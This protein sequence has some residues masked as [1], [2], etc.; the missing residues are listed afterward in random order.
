MS[1]IG[2][3]A[4]PK[5]YGPYEFRLGDELRGER[6]TLGRSLLD[7]QR[8]LRIKAAYVAAIENCDPSVFPNPSF[9]A[10]YVRSY[11][12]YLGLDPD[13]IYWR[14][15]QESSFSGTQ[16]ARQTVKAES[17]K[18]AK[19]RL[20][21]RRPAA[22]EFFPHFPLAETPRRSVAELPVSALGSMI[23]MLALIGA[24]GYGGWSIL[25]NIQRVQ[26]APVDEVPVALDELQAF[27]APEASSAEQ[28]L[29]ELASPV[30]ATALVDLY[31]Q[32]ELEVPI[33]VPRDG[34]IAA[35]DPD[36][37]GLLARARP[38]GGAV[39]SLGP[40]ALP[41]SSDMALTDAAVADEPFRVPA[42]PQVVE[43]DTRPLLTVI[44]ERPAWIRVYLSDGT[45]IFERILESGEVYEVP[46]TAASPL[47]WAGNSGSVYVRV[48]DR[49]HGPLGSGTRANR[50]VV[51]DAGAIEEH[52]SVVNEIPTVISETLG[53]LSR[54]DERVLR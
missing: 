8:D 22:G 33:L 14:F 28:S 11:A 52:F 10:G 5:A 27:T 38:G 2:S 31:R 7:I 46:P 48:G 12:R 17:S 24:L 36:K 42:E 15:C 37:I 54:S 44:A 32:Q 30:A 13:E 43:E 45:I 34:P 26:F 47:I 1:E 21:A 6:A 19:R 9:I 50:D 16:A 3:V 35:L 20:S 51:L 25:K 18:P 53:T 41:S 40:I 23:V 4:R 39:A 29:P 49:L